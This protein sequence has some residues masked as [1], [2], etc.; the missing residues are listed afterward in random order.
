MTTLGV[1]FMPRNPT[2]REMLRCI[3]EAYYDEYV[4]FGKETTGR[5]TKAYVPLNLDLVASR[6]AIDPELVFG[7]LYYHLQPKFGSPA[8]NKDIQFFLIE[9]AHGGRTDRHVINFALLDSALATM[10]YEHDKFLRPW[11]LSLFSLVI[12]GSALVVTLAINFSTLSKLL[13]R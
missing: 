12:A 3:Y 6:L 4:S 8:G 2:D 9:I 13:T 1:P 10:D 11:K 7:R 5:I